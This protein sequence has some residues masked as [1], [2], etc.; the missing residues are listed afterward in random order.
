MCVHAFVCVY[1]NTLNI[2]H[3]NRSIY[4]NILGKHSSR[5]A[6]N[7][8][9]NC[10]LEY[11]LRPNPN[12]YRTWVPGSES[13]NKTNYKTTTMILVGMRLQMEDGHTS[14]YLT[15]GKRN[16]ISRSSSGRIFTDLDTIAFLCVQ[17]VVCPGQWLCR[18]QKIL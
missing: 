17:T 7:R 6:A 12:R 4:S 8:I 16:T 10:T 13:A 9:A 1:M 11:E 15:M 14:L 3:T 2:E 18:N 5:L